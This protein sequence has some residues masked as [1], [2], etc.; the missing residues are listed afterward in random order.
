MNKKTF[1]LLLATA[2]VLGACST[3]EDGAMET[4]KNPDNAIAFSSEN[5]ALTRTGFTGADTKIALLFSSQ[6]GSEDSYKSCTTFATGQKNATEG[7]TEYSAVS[8]TTEEQRYWDDC[9][10]RAAKLSVYGFAVPNK[11][12]ANLPITAASSF[13]AGAGTK[14][15]TIAVPQDQTESDIAALDLTYSNNI[16][17]TS[18][19]KKGIY[20]YNFSTSKY[21]LKESATYPTD[22]RLVFQA[23]GS[24]TEAGK[25]NQGHLIFKHAMCW[26]TVNLIEGTEGFDNSA[27]TDFVLTGTKN[28]TLNVNYTG[29][30]NVESGTW[31]S[32]TDGAI[33]GMKDISAA[34]ANKST[35]TLDAMTLPDKTLDNVT[36][37]FLTFEID[38]NLY[39]V[40][41]DEIAE[42]IKTKASSLEAGDL[43]TRLTSFSAMTAGD[44]Y[45]INITV[46][47]T[48]IETITAEV[49]QWEQ[50]NADYTAN[51]ARIKFTLRDD[52]NGTDIITTGKFDI[53]RSADFDENVT[54]D[55]EAYNWNTNDYVKATTL[56]Y[57]NNFFKTN[58]F[59][60]SNKEYYHLRTISPINTPLESGNKSFAIQSG[61]QDDAHDYQWGAPYYVAADKKLYYDVTNGFQYYSDGTTKQLFKAIGPTNSDIH[62]LLQHMMSDVNVKLLTTTGSDKV[63]IEGATVELIYFAADGSVNIGNGLITPTTTIT[64]TATMTANGSTYTYRVVPQALTRTDGTNKKIGIK[65]TTSDKNQYYL[66]EDLSTLEVASITD[67]GNNRY[68][69]GNTID[70]WFPGYSYTYNITIKKTGIETITAEIVNWESVTA[71]KT[72]TL[73]SKK[74]FGFWK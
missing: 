24:D 72:V 11:S 65:I 28:A 47:K 35:L 70:R 33:A 61:A 51:N 27:T 41:C 52:T 9:F 66:V 34:K 53:Y 7:A 3:N 4:V 8:F 23:K 26:V 30:F 64:N 13:A 22:G 19:A 25:F 36:T 46:K 1:P 43:K 69:A 39:H 17:S 50:V 38:H 73:E 10:G 63:N 48:Q 59:W 56:T 67:N 20:D 15:F 18:W 57:E 60:E 21:S 54:D 5:T 44:H 49:V 71:D 31:T 16:Q 2:M 74:G 29:T 37:D 45:T 6:N 40:S 58:W 12:D 55:R 32:K 14:A 42:A 62:M 68:T